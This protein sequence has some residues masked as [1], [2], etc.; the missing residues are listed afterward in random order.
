VDRKQFQELSKIRL[1]E[2]S[3]LLKLG[4]PDGAYYLAGYAVECA[5][6]ACISKSTRRYEFP[7][8]E[9]VRFSYTHDLAQ[10]VRV[11]DLEKARK[12]QAAKDPEF[13]DNWERVKF[14]SEKSRYQKNQPDSAKILFE[15]G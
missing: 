4:M 3:A 12:D 7:D 15:S 8:A 5:L 9:K 11:A 13:S 10:L 2:A 14:W 6:K 1:K